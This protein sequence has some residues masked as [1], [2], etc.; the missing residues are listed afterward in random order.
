MKVELEKFFAFL[1]FSDQFYP[2]PIR[3]LTDS[4]IPKSMN[5]VTTLDISSHTRLSRLRAT[6][7]TIAL[8]IDIYYYIL[9]FI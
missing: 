1:D 2:F 8:I 6:V 9:L 5:V 3:Q 4:N 7:S